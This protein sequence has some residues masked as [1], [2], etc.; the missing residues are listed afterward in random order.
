MRELYKE[1]DGEARRWLTE[2]FEATCVERREVC[3]DRALSVWD[4]LNGIIEDRHNYCDGVV[5]A[6]AESGNG[7]S[8]VAV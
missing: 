7:W 2:S 6:T 3:L 8:F 5:Y 4:Q 1:L